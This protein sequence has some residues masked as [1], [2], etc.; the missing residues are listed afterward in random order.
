KT[1]P[2]P[3]RRRAGFRSSDGPENTFPN[4]PKEDGSDKTRRGTTKAE[5][6]GRKMTM[7]KASVCST[8]LQKEHRSRSTDS[9]V[10][11]PPAKSFRGDKMPP[12]N[13]KDQ[14]REK[15]NCAPRAPRPGIR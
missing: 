3:R 8:R 2:L 11:P 1:P 10:A 6:A 7:D 9:T 12:G 13:H 4:P 5:T 15:R 14:S